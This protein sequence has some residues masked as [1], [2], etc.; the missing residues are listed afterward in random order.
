MSVRSPSIPHKHLLRLTTTI[1]GTLILALT[2]PSTALAQPPSPLLPATDSSRQLA[3][4]FWI[5]L[6]I[7]VVVFV[8]VEG[9]L[10]FAIVRYRSRGSEEEVRQVDGNPTLEVMWTI[11]PALIM[12]VLFSLALRTLTLQH[13]VPADATTVEVTGH[14]WYWE[15]NY[16]DTEV[17]TRNHLVIPANEPVLLEIG[18]ADVIHSFWVPQLEGKADAIPG[19]T[20]ILWFEAD[21]GTYAGQC[22][23]FC[24]L[25]HYAM[26]FDVTVLPA[27]EYDAWMQQQI[28]LAAQFQPIGTDLES[29][30][31]SGDPAHGEALFT[32][33]GCSSCHTTDG[34]QLVGP[35]LLGVGE[36]AESRID[37]YDVQQYLRESIL[38]PCDYVVEGF[39][40]VMPQNFGERLEAKDLA[41]IIA[42][43]LEQ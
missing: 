18:S 21:E 23:E 16:P 37:G 11:V 5:I 8:V 4:L 36:R 1:T 20:N 39:T 28:E 26:L 40:C 32:D 13:S 42:Y 2:I 33:L 7:A 10:I 12:V 6:A 22:A 35:T 34:T 9:L 25:E 38:L 41:D 14:Q 29:P 31:P 24:G 30:L 27:D 17:T 15:F 43:L 3:S 19:H